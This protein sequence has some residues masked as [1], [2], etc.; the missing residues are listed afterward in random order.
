MNRT[1]LLI[2]LTGVIV[3]SSFAICS[4]E[5]AIEPK[6]KIVLFDGKSFDGWFRYLRN[7]QGDVDETWKVKRGGILACAGEP[8]GYIRTTKAY[9]NYKFH[10]E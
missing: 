9:K 10:I 6:N 1:A 3:F 5:P 7:N 2:S 4:A 8:R